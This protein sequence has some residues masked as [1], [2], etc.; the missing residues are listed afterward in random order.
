MK[1]ILNVSTKLAITGSLSKLLHS[2]TVL[3]IRKCVLF[4][5]L[6]VFFIVILSLFF[7]STIQNK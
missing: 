1:I 5:K 2:E 7:F 3:A 6:D 4:S